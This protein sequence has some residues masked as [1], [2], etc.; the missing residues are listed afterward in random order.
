MNHFDEK[1]D[2]VLERFAVATHEVEAGEDESPNFDE[3]KAAIK[4]L[5]L[6]AIDK[7]EKREPNS[8]GRY[9]ACAELRAVLIGGVVNDYDAV[10]GE[11]RDG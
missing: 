8:N 1:L 10:K 3:A 5:V 2:G 9:N 7:I 4:Q 11:S 6:D